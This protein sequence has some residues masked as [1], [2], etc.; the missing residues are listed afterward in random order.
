[1]KKLLVL[2]A[3]GLVLVLTACGDDNG[4]SANNAA[5]PT[6]TTCTIDDFGMNMVMTVRH[7]DGYITEMDVVTRMPWSDLG[8]DASDL[9]MDPEDFADLMS[10]FGFGAGVTVDGDY[11]VIDM[12]GLFDDIIAEEDA[13]H[14]D[15]F[16]AEVE[17]DG[18]NCQ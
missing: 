7:P 11:L 3:T 9:D 10:L 14:I 2:A 6:E 13:M 4:G 1:M 17:E 15:E 5:A 8:L 18:G 12:S 16:I